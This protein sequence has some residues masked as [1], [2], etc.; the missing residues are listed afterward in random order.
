MHVAACQAWFGSAAPHAMGQ[1]TKSRGGYARR[2]PGAPVLTIS[3]RWSTKGDARENVL[4][5]CQD[6]GSSREHIHAH[7]SPSVSTAVSHGYAACS[8]HGKASLARMLWRRC[9]GLPAATRPRA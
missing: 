5:S 2:R 6:G 3:A 1:I 8:S 4:T 9:A 7:F